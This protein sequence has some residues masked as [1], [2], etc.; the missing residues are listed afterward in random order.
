MLK[1]V[2]VKDFCGIEAARIN[3]GKVTI[4]SGRSMQGKSTIVEAIRWAIL[5]G[6][7]E[8]FI[9]N[10]CESCDIVLR[11]DQSSIITRSMMRGGKSRLYFNRIVDGESI[12]IDEPQTKLNKLFIP[13]SFD[14]ISLMQMKP[15]ELAK[16]VNEAL[17]DRVKLTPE[18]LVELGFT[19]KEFPANGNHYQIAKDMHDALY[20][21]RTEVNRDVK[22]YETKAKDIIQGGNS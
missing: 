5:G 2:E 13:A 12:S 11:T 17:S 15:K 7:E 3:L 14:P 4:I 21:E 18:E 1:V 22:E 8:S 9:R 19:D 16:T 6:N 20:A 10:G